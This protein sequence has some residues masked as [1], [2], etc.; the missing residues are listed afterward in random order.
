MPTLPTYASPEAC[1]AA[2]D[3]APSVSALRR[4]SRICQTVARSIEDGLNAGTFYPVV[5]ERSWRA[6]GRGRLWFPRPLVAV[7]ALDFDGTAVTGYAL[8]PRFTGPPYEWADLLDATSGAPGN[9]VV[10]VTGTWGW[11]DASRTVADLAGGIDASTTT[12]TVDDA[13]QFG[14]YDLIAV[15]S[16]RMVVTGRALATT[17]TTL[18]GNPTAS[19]ADTTIGVASGAAVAQGETIVVDSERMLVLDISGNN[20]LVRRAVDGTTLA[21]HTAS[22]TVYAHRALTVERGAL[23]TTAAAHLDGDDVL[24][25]TPPDLIAELAIAEAQTILGQE[26]AGWLA[27]VGQGESEQEAT[28]RSLQSIRRDARA[29]FR[30]WNSGA[31]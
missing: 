18:S 22:T 31:L 19:A 16:E 15:G 25:H 8:E 1:A 13:S 20:L 5:D 14:T 29:R 23:G 11:T 30:R 24:R 12:V 21:A 10:T 17:G 3:I 4:L 9:G 2:F 26:G 7:T 28:G 6:T 27:T